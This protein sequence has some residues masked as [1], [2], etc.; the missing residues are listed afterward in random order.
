MCWVG[1]PALLTGPFGA[2]NQ[3]VREA[4][5]T[6]RPEHWI[7]VHGSG[8]LRRAV[9]EGLRWREMY[10]GERVALEFGYGFEAVPSSRCQIG[11]ALASSDDAAT[12]ETCWW[13]RALRYRA[14][15]CHR[16]DAI[17]VVHARVSDGDGGAEEGIA[18]QIT[19]S[20]WPSW[21]PRDRKLVALTV[22]KDGRTV[23]PC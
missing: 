13:A 17:K 5:T 2:Y 23:N 1:W 11:D 7:A 15:R 22:G 20:P 6:E 14:Q 3:M 4:L 18:I 21:L 16:K 8:S 19:P 12:T 10:L 9:E